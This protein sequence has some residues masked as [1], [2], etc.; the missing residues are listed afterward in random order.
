MRNG[1][2]KWTAAEKLR[3]VLAGM[4]PNIEVSELCR[5]EGINPT[6]YYGWKKQ[7]LSSAT[8]VFDERATRPNASEER[9]E[10]ELRRMKSV[11]AEITAEN[12]E[13]KKG[14]SE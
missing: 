9:K 12:L 2:R 1:R 5:R 7:L 3:I 13:L 14:L 8:K 11:I 6:Q 4:Q 10:A